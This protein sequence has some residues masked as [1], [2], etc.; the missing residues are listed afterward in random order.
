M[1]NASNNIEIPATV[2]PGDFPL[3]SPQ[4][5]AAAR[6]ILNNQ[7]PDVVITIS[8]NVGDG[9]ARSHFETREDGTRVEIRRAPYHSA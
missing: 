3:G 9:E 1:K 4:S 7:T 2:K 6:A 8:S 5:R